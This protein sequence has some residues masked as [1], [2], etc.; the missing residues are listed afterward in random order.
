VASRG[1]DFE[2]VS[3]IILYDPPSSIIDYSNKI[4]RTARINKFG[5]SLLFL[6][7]S[8]FDFIN[9]LEAKGM[10]TNTEINSW[11]FRF[12]FKTR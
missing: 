11:L 9:E 5:K 12:S 1:L 7:K 3:I 10:E 6:F 8:E 4:G 2:E